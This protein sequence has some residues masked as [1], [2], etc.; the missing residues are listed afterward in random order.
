[1][2]KDL[3]KGKSAGREPAGEKKRGI[4]IK[5]KRYYLR[6][7]PL[8]S[9]KTKK[10]K[11]ASEGEEPRRQSRFG[12]ALL[13]LFA[14]MVC[15]CFII[16]VG[17]LG[18]LVTWMVESP[19]VDLTRFEYN[20]ASTVYDINDNFYQQL[21]TNEV[22]EIVEIKQIPELVS[23]AFVS[24]EDQRFY[25]HF[26]VDIRGTLKAVIGVLT[27]GSTEGMG[28]STITQ[29]LIKQT[30]L[31]SATSVRRKVMEWK[32]SYQ[33]EQMLSKREILEAYLNKINLSEAW[34][35]Q[36]AARVYFG[37]DVGELSL[38]QSA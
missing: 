35:I 28:G 37:K 24:I 4:V 21:Q 26:G 36:S 23:L 8:I 13:R 6:A 25:S 33:L 15:L 38:A 5:D 11:N 2:K 30:H 3:K 12:R 1:M 27:S 14:V 31:S 10:K 34:G 18:V 16:G 19:Q 17:G 9:G 29:Q 32:L 22:R 20:G 7:R